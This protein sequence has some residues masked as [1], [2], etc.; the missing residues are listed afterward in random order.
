VNAT[1]TAAATLPLAS[2]VLQ[3]AAGDQVGV[4]T[5]DLPAGTTLL[6]GAGPNGAGQALTVSANVPRGH[7][8]ALKPVSAGAPLH[9][10][11]QSI[12]RALTDI[13]AGDHVHTHNLGMDEVKQDYE[14]APPGH[15][16]GA[17]RTAPHV[18]GLPPAAKAGTGTTS[19][20]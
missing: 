4:A 3:L 15:A 11:G 14:L 17:G 20:F 6:A 2:C 19:A 5:R 1:E 8:I 9:K 13:R 7:K 16:S 18:Q 12:G 10:Y